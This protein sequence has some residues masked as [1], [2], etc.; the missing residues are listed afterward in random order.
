MTI[1]HIGCRLKSIKKALFSCP[2]IFARVDKSLLG[3]ATKEYRR[4]V[5]NAERLRHAVAHSAEV[6]T[7]L[8]AFELNS[9]KKGYVG[10]GLAAGKGSTTMYQD[11]LQGDL[12]TVTHEGSVFTYE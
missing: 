8:A 7:D 6:T 5:P 4:Y 11:C 12:F 2:T 10:A 9:V 3:L 1:Y